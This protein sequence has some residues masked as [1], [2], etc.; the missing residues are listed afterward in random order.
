MG[1]GGGGISSFIY[2]FI[3]WKQRFKVCSFFV[4]WGGRRG[5]F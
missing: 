3:Y 2:L 5:R 1:S 4:V